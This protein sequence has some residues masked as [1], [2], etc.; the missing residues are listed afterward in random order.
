MRMEI[1]VGA[2]SL[3]GGY[4]VRIRVQRR[5]FEPGCVI[6]RKENLDSGPTS[7][8]LLGWIRRARQG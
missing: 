2:Q 5:A 6:G 7:V 4:L 3:Q 1:E 8:S